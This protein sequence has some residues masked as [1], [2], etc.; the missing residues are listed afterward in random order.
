VSLADLNTWLN[1]G[2]KVVRIMPN[3]PIS[4]TEGL[5]MICET[6]VIT[7]DELEYIIKVLSSFGKVEVVDEKNI[8]A[9]V[10]L[11]L[12]RLPLCSS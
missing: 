4:V 3:I 9:F 6:D 8:N 5:T 11:L 10:A 12:L 2:T 7:K 1:A